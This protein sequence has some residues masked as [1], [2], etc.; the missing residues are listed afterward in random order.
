MLAEPSPQTQEQPWPTCARTTR[1][2]WPGCCAAA[3]SRPARSSPRTSSGSRRSTAGQRGRHPLLRPGA[4][5]AAAADE[6][7]AR[8][9]APGPLHGLP[10]AHKDLIE[11]AGV[12]TTYGSPLFAD[13]VPDR[14]RARGAADG[15]RRGDQPGQDQHARVRRPARTPSTRSSAPPATRTTSAAARRQQR[16]RGGALAAR[17]IC[18]A[19]GSDLGGS[20]RNPASFCNVVGLRPSPGRVPRWPVADVAD[21]LGVAGRWRAP[22]PTPRC[23]WRPGGPGPAGAARARRAAARAAEPGADRRAARPGPARCAGGVERG[24]RPAG[25]AGRARVLAPARQVLADLGCE[26]VDAAPD[27]SGAD[28][29]FRTWRAFRFATASGRCCASTPAS[30]G[31]T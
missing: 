18:L 30:S 25:R 15:R 13:Y 8:G 23:C 6:A 28:E 2:R 9:E 20:L 22:S 12:R 31:P 17:M 7:L 21:T 1:S 29:V 4:G 10:V 5:Q 14:R 19:D 3:R 27:L 11:T 24:P 16:R 26:V